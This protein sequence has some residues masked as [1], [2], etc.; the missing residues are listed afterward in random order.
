MTTHEA[1]EQIAVIHPAG[2]VM[3]LR[4]Q[5]HDILTHWTKEPNAQGHMHRVAKYVLLS[6][7]G[8]QS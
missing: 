3:E 4:R 1:R 5:G 6:R 8:V 2:R 7:K